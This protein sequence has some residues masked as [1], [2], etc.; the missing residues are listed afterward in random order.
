MDDDWIKIE[1]SLDLAE[2]VMD[3]ASQGALGCGV[4]L[5]C[6]KAIA[7][8]DDLIPGS[9]FHDCVEVRRLLEE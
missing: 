2:V 7:S 3:W 6:G 5:V 8:E 9:S 1:P 4:C